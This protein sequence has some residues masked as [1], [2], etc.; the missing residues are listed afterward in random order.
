MLGR[1]RSGGREKGGKG[2]KRVM[3]SKGVNLKES[4]IEKQV[5]GSEGS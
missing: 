4:I 3:V 5:E 1:N 2:R